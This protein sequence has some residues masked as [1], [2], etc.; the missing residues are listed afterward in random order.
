MINNH[1]AP[2][3]KWRIH[4]DNK[5]IEHISQGEFKIQLTMGINFI[6]FIPDSDES[7]TMHTKSDN[8]AVM[9]GSET[10]EVIEELFKSFLQ[11]YQEGLEE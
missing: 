11:R 9:V 4:S 2:K 5:I 8:I 1:K 10:D 6:S 7:R 3:E